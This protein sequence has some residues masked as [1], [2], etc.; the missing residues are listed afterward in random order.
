MYRIEIVPSAL[1]NLEDIAEYVV[2]HLHNPTLA[3]KITDGILDAIDGLC[4][5]PYRCRIYEQAE[6]CSMNI[7]Y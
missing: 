3:D 7:E 4:F 2:F 6:I 1:K 5:F